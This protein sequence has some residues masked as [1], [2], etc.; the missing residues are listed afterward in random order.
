MT[1][2]APTGGSSERTSRSEAKAERR[3]DLLAAAAALMARRGYSA[4]R[5]EDI[6]AAVG[7]SGPA[8]YRH[9]ANKQDLLAQLLTDVS[10]RLLHGGSEVV[11]RG[12]A[13]RERLADLVAFHVRFALTEPDLI[14]VQSR[15][16][17]SLD[18]GPRAVVRRLQRSYVDLWADT[19]VD[20]LG[21]GREDGLARA[22]AVFGLINAAPRMPDLPP[23]TAA[24]LLTAM[25]GQAL[26]ATT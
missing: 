11:A 8:M 26:T 10:E 1:A 19:V 20:V 25:A 4:V 12:D 23:D 9:F 6:G 3:R 16:L 22:H 15:D 24:R 13:P 14:A 5:L 17:A 18:E 7:V 2:S 21:V